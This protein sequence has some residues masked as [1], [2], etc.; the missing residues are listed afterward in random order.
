[1]PALSG[2]DRQR[3]ARVRAGRRDRLSVIGD[4]EFHRGKFSAKN[5]KLGRFVLRGT[6]ALKNGVNAIFRKAARTG[7]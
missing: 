7:E 5:S 2:L 1:M 6:T 3:S 4:R